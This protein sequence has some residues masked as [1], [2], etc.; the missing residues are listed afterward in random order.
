M[1]MGSDMFFS[2][3]DEDSACFQ[4]VAFVP[5]QEELASVWKVDFDGPVYSEGA[6]TRVWMRSPRIRA[7][8]YSYKL[9]FDFLNNEV[10]YEAMI[11]AIMALKEL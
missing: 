8:R 11:L 6:G 3:G 5:T 9:A 10:Q 7:L 4:N 1:E 2:K